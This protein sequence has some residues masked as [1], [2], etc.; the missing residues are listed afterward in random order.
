[1]QLG[2]GKVKDLKFAD[3]STM[4]VLWEF[5]GNALQALQWNLY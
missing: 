3:D 2:D 4:L 1:V 5:E